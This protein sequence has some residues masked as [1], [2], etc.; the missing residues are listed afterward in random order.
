MSVAT[1][2]EDQLFASVPL[3]ARL[4]RG[5]DQVFELKTMQRRLFDNMMAS[6]EAGG[7]ARPPEVHYDDFTNFG[8]VELSFTQS[9]NI[10]SDLEKA[11][12]QAQE[13]DLSNSLAGEIAYNATLYAIQVFAVSLQDLDDD[14]MVEPIMKRWELVSL[15]RDGVTIKVHFY[16][17][18]RVS[19]GENPDQ[20]LVQLELS[21]YPDKN[22]KTLP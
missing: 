22:G 1:L 20:L 18:L 19:T 3:A 14:E 15:R 4:T 5:V 2:S 16:E 7:G 12:K 17:P 21:V 9:L 6:S 11:I 8:I 10:P 13:Q